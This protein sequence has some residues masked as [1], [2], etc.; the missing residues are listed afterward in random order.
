MSTISSTLFSHC[1]HERSACSK[2]GCFPPLE[3]STLHCRVKDGLGT[4]CSTMLP[5]TV[6]KGAN[7]FM[8]GK[9]G[10]GDGMS[11]RRK[12][13]KKKLQDLVALVPGISTLARE[14]PR[15]VATDALESS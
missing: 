8:D 12:K 1:K 14:V 6:G 9:L 4:G 3:G 2:F 10:I 15:G 13:E 5:H 7:E 11:E